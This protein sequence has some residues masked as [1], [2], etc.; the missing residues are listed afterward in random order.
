MD[1]NEALKDKNE[2]MAGIKEDL[3]ASRAR[4]A[5]FDLRLAELGAELNTISQQKTETIASQNAALRTL[6]FLENE[7]IEIEEHIALKIFNE[8][9]DGLLSQQKDFWVALKERLVYQR[10]NH[11]TALVGFGE[12]PDPDQVITEVRRGV[13]RPNTF[14]REAIAI[15]GAEATYKEVLRGLCEAKVKGTGPSAA[16]KQET[17]RVI[18][19]LL[20]HP[21]FEKRWNK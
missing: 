17:T 2:E 7:I 20:F 4:V 14:N 18:D 13:G 19:K 12:Q 9:V 8:K 16:E 11:A 1:H 10:H 21:D 5:E 3:Q 6:R 15:R